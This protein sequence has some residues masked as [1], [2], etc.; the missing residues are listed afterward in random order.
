MNEIE[1]SH[2]FLSRWAKH[3]RGLLLATLSKTENRHVEQNGKSTHRQCNGCTSEASKVNGTKLPDPI[4]PR[5][6][7]KAFSPE[8]DSNVAQAWYCQEKWAEQ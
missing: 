4:D 3:A 7:S 5:Q 6:K 8:K 1:L 2:A